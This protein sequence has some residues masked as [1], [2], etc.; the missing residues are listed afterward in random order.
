[1][2]CSRWNYLSARTLSHLHLHSTHSS[3]HTELPAGRSPLARHTGR[4]GLN[5]SPAARRTETD[6]RTPHHVAFHTDSTETGWTDNFWWKMQRKY[7]SE[8]ISHL[9]EHVALWHF[10]MMRVSPIME[11]IAPL[12]RPILTAVKVTLW[13]L[14]DGHSWNDDW[15]TG[16]Y[17]TDS[18]EQ[19]GAQHLQG[20]RKE[21]TIRQIQQYHLKFFKQQN[22]CLWQKRPSSGSHTFFFLQLSAYILMTKN[23]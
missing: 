2:Y 4:S 6:A 17:H 12:L 1:M 18:C 21:E 7:S 23:F 19:Y 22:H 16:A 3:L 9:K 8:A 5:P 13:S 14:I 10:I 15:V 20:E 11:R